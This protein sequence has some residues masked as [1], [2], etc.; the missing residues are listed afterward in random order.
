MGDMLKAKLLSHIK[1]KLKKEG[2]DISDVEGIHVIRV[3]KKDTTKVTTE[4]K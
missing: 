3:P 1:T 4:K 2:R